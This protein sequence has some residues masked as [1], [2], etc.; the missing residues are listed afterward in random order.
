MSDRRDYLTSQFPAVSLF[1]PQAPTISASAMD[2]P[3]KREPSLEAKFAAKQQA[4]AKG[5]DRLSTQHMIF[6]GDARSMVA[7]GTAERVQLVVTSPPYFNLVEYQDSTGEQLGNFEEY[8]T[9]LAELRKVWARCFELLEPG[10]RMCV[11]VGDVC[12]SRRQGGRHYLLPLH[13]DITKASQ[14]IGFDYLNP[15]LWCKI[16]N[17]TTEVEGNGAPFLGKPYEPNAIIKNNVEYILIFRKPGSY[18]SPTQEQRDLSVIDKEDHR[19]WFRQI[20]ED[21]PGQSRF[22]GHPAPFPV[23]L[24]Y[25]LISMFSFVGD[26]VLDPFCGTGTTVEAAMKAHRNSVAYEIEPS[27]VDITR[28]RFAQD[29]LGA[30]VVWVAADDHDGVKPVSIENTDESVSPV[31]I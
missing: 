16:A 20:W 31:P 12:I 27:Y 3:G 22:R 28:Q 5:S 15:I 13:A 10:G 29:R 26:T 4:W 25:R 11:V 18:R 7:L 17:A 23:E 14:E 6:R 19:K 9:F 1:E 8:N 30:S 24:A 2:K 21:V